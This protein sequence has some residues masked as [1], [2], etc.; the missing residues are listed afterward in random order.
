[1]IHKRNYASREGTNDI[2]NRAIDDPSVEIMH[3]SR[4]KKKNLSAVIV[5][6]P[7]K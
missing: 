4:T 7:R 3:I 2:N 5:N 6:P 1:M